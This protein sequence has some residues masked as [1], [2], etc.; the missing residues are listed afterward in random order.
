MLNQKLWVKT[1]KK[2][3]ARS[4]ILKS[5]AV[6]DG[7][8]TAI[9]MAGL[10]GAGKTEFS[11]NLLKN[12]DNKPVRLDMDEIATHID[13]YSPEKA[14]LYRGGATELLNKTFDL[15]IKNKLDFIMDG[16]FSS[17]YAKNNVKRALAHGYNVKI[18]YLYQDPKLAWLFTKEREKVEY[19]AI[20]K[21]G[22][23]DSFSRTID[24]IKFIMENHKHDKIVLDIIIKDG[25]SIKEWNN[26]ISVEEIDK[27]INKYYNKD[28]LKEYIDG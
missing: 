15:V 7:N 8:P 5:G 18:I 21:S 27:N 22:F 25:Y 12:L 13:G 23:I 10:P 24:N 19:R 1:H 20:D 16:T 17:K 14:D 28:N 9:F 2:E 6:P 26:N 11:K 3:F 4:L